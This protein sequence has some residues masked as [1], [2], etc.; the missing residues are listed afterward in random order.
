MMAVPIRLT[1]TSVEASK[2]QVLFESNDD[3][4][5]EVSHDGQRF[6]LS[7]PIEGQT[8]FTP[9]TVDTN[10]QAGQAK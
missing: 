8:A 6:L 10:W 7:F 9:I 4:R 1:A 5:F 3:L 2:P